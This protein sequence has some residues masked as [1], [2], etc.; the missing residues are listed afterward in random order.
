M[1][2]NTCI[3]VASAVLTIALTGCQR[4]E[5]KVES[6]QQAYNQAEKEFRTDCSEESLKLPTSLSA[7]CSGEKQKMD[8]AYKKLQDQRAKQ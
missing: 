5:A 6:V 4:Q 1:R 8:D 3:I 2:C 7:K